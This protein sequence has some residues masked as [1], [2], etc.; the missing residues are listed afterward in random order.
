MQNAEL[1]RARG[2]AEA[3]AD[4]FS[5]LYDFAPLGY[6]TLND[7]GRI[8]ELNL[9]AP[10]LLGVPRVS[11]VG[12]SFISRVAEPHRPILRLHLSEAAAAEGE[13]ITEVDLLAGP[14]TLLPVQLSTLR[15][16][17]EPNSEPRFRMAI[18]DISARKEAELE[19]QREHG[20]TVA[21]LESISD[22]FLSLDHALRVIYINRPAELLL[23]KRRQALMGQSLS[24]ALTDATRSDFLRA[25]QRAMREDRA[26]SFDTF[27]APLNSWYSVRAY[28]S[29]AG[30]TVYFADITMRK[31]AEEETRRANEVLEKRV[32]ERTAKITALL[33][34]SKAMQEQLRQMSHV[35][36]RA[37][38]AERKRI[39]RELHDQVAQ[40][41]IGV[42]LDLTNLARTAEGRPGALRR[43]IVQAQRLMEASVNS[44]QR[45]AQELRP[46]MLDDLGL[47]PALESCLREFRQRTGIRV[48]LASFRGV[49]QMSNAG[50]T[51]LYRVAQAALANVAQH[52]RAG[53]VKVHI[54]R[55]PK[56]VLLEVEDDGA[57]FDPD[58]RA[59]DGRREHL[60]LLGMKERVEMA[61]GTFA[62]ESSPGHGTII[63]AHIPRETRVRGGP[64]S[65]RTI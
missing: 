13:V 56:T 29:A 16:R 20:R 63:R 41:L 39:S 49:E 45:F 35:V 14:D 2:E 19:L 25:I 53:E 38:E 31:R 10:R 24:R 5:D 26:A 6:V 33:E 43:G 8:L 18:T 57:G 7:Q 59:R 12:A 40:S 47:V 58:R 9:T 4:R 21:I 23:G 54:L 50:Q 61:G 48:S 42:N 65:K 28:P 15:S 55:R 37:Q 62:L 30:V 32:A 1:E 52:A 11:L 46:P 51:V 17:H 27:V 44:L 60:G 36:L 3:S 22:G 64:A 34:Q